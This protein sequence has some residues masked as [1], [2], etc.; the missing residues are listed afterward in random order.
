[1]D[2]ASPKPSRPPALARDR[3]TVLTYSLAAVFGYAIGSLGPAMPLLRDDLGISRTTGGLHFTLVALGSVAVGFVADRAAHRWGRRTLFWLGGASVGAGILLIG[4]GR[5]PAV[6]LTGAALIG[7]PGSAMLATIQST[8][9]DRH[10]DHRAV[11]LTEG[12]TATSFGTVVPAIVIGALVAAGAGWRPALAVPAVAWI[13]L[14]VFWGRAPFPPPARPRLRGEAAALPRSYWLFWG[15]LIPSV[16]AEWSVGA[17]GA[18]Y[19]VDV[20]GTSEGFASASMTAFFGAMA[21][22]RLIGSRVARH[23]EPVTILVGSLAVACCGFGVFW[24]GTTP[25]VVVP[26]LFLTGLGISI[27]F[28]MLLSLALGAARGRS[29][30]A[31]A[32]VSIAAGS[33]VVVAPITLGWIAD[34]AGIR[35]AFGAVP[36]LLVA[37]AVLA[38]AGR[39]AARREQ[40]A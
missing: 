29:D 28:P 5:H 35:A 22:G 21:F 9:A 26:G 27:L 39:R 19:L 23:A 36:G 40:T 37:V 20:A 1:V 16:G 3:L 12:N 6:T 11:V 13:V 32:R 10:P 33:A 14:Y 18:G 38:L 15:A 31:S 4:A 7:G 17:W 34:R 2:T 30:T 25:A 24:A 8:L